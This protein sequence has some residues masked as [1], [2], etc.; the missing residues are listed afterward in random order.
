[1]TRL[2]KTQQRLKRH[3]E[4]IAAAAA[5]ANEST[6]TSSDT[7]DDNTGAVGPPLPPLPAAH[8]Q[9]P[10]NNSPISGTTGNNRDISNN[11]TVDVLTSTQIKHNTLCE[12]CGKPGRLLCC[13]GCNLVFHLSCTRPILSSI[14]TG[15][16][17]CP[18]CISN[19][20]NVLESDRLGAI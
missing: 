4:A 2:S 3:R 5:A 12:T 6:T 16:W 8:N 9:N 17:N 11:S 14:P 15:Q 7:N 20:D 1:M 18:F 10:T 19:N 13:D